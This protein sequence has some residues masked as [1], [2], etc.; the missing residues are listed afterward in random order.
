MKGSTILDIFETYS[1]NLGEKSALILEDGL[2]FTYEELDGLASHL[3]K[4]LAAAIARLTLAASAPNNKDNDHHQQHHNKGS[5]VSAEATPL[6]AVMMTRGVSLVASILGILKAGAAYVPVDPAF[7]PDRQSHIFSH[8]KCQVLITDAESY[9]QAQSLGVIFPPT[10][11]INSELL[12]S[13]ARETKRRGNKKLFTPPPGL[14]LRTLSLPLV[15]QILDDKTAI[16]QQLRS[17]ATLREDGGLMYVLYTSGSTGK[18]KGVMVKQ[19][20]VVNIVEW[21]A[22]ALHVS[23]KSRV[24]GLTTFCFDISVLEMFLPLIRGAGLVM[25]NQ[26]SQKDPFQLLDVIRDRGVTVVQATP[27]TYEMLF[28]TGWKGDPTID[29]LVG[30]EAFRPSIIPLAKNCRSL[31]NVCKYHKLFASSA[32]HNL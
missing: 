2:S 30:G 25:V 22:E 13:K 27:T 29:F 11:V 9:D 8:S 24:L 18:P 26:S 21:F 28:A 5:P 14:V 4:E 23:P 10:I 31:R 17:D 19:A 3:G 32:L 16:M 7:P 1:K 6:V 12:L 15:E 20:G